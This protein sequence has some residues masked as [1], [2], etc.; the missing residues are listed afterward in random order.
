MY[1]LPL[2]VPQVNAVAAFDDRR[3]VDPRTAQIGETV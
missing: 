3:P 2:G 1:R